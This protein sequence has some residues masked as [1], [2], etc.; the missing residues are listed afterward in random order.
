MESS[1]SLGPGTFFASKETVLIW[2]LL[3]PSPGLYPTAACLIIYTL[4]MMNYLPVCFSVTSYLVDY[5]EVLMDYFI[6]VM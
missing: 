6:S 1:R 5:V 4:A 3:S 2:L